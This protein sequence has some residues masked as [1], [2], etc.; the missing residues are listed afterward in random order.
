[1]ARYKYL[2]LIWLLPLAFLFLSLHQT[3]VYFSI[4]DTYQ[5]GESYTAEVVEFEHKQIAAQNSTYIILRFEDGRN[6][7]VQKRLSLPVEMAGDLRDIRV[8]PIRY[9]PGS[10]QEIVLMPAYETQKNLVWSNIAMAVLALLITLL[11]AAGVHRFATNK[12]RSE[13]EIIEYERID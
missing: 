8:I 5:N 7:E 9:N 1:M 6:N 11:I 12:L 3:Y 13:P 10:F 2:Y 4:S